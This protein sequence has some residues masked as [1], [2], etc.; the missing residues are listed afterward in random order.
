L[1]AFLPRRATRGPEGSEAVCCCRGISGRIGDFEFPTTCRGAQK[2]FGD[3][4]AA[5]AFSF[6][7]KRGGRNREKF[8]RSTH[9]GATRVKIGGGG[10]PAT[11]HRL[12]DPEV[13][14]ANRG[15][16]RGG[17]R[18]GRPNS[19][20][21]RCG[22]EPLR[23]R[24][25]AFERGLK[26]RGLRFFFFARRFPNQKKPRLRGCGGP[27]G[28]GPQPRNSCVSRSVFRP[29]SSPGVGGKKSAG[30]G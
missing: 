3:R 15:T 2:R 14:P 19:G 12:F 8:G 21:R 18:A 27:G 20:A 22:G 5:R 25:G 7:S 24:S 23:P 30:R 17:V 29:C 28:K 26:P 4:I 6:C 9:Q 1:T 16:T 11:N 10:W 13:G